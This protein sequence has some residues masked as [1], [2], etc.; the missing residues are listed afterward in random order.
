[1]TAVALIC[2]L[3][4]N[5][6]VTVLRTDGTFGC[7]KCEFDSTEDACIILEEAGL[8]PRGEAF[9]IVQMLSRRLW[10]ARGDNVA[11]EVLITAGFIYDASPTNQ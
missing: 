2:E 5:V 3:M 9:N 4:E 11:P 6:R 8:L 7:W 1:M 10:T